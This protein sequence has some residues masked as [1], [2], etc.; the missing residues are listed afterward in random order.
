MRAGTLWVKMAHTIGD[1]VSDY[2][3]PSMGEVG[4]NFDDK[5]FKDHG[6]QLLGNTSLF[7]PHSVVTFMRVDGNHIRLS[8]DYNSDQEKFFVHLAEIKTE[9]WNDMRW[10]LHRVEVSEPLVKQIEETLSSLILTARFPAKKELRDQYFKTADSIHL[11]TQVNHECY[12][13][14]WMYEN[15]QRSTFLK[16]VSQTLGNLIETLRKQGE[17]LSKDTEQQLLKELKGISNNNNKARSGP[18]A[19]R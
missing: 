9:K 2:L 6:S 3:Y 16:R 19:V 13:T 5:S 14:A 4:L 18:D 7:Y 15:T 10:T 17:K 11:I 12:I 8:F 1:E